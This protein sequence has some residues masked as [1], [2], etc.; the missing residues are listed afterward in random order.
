MLTPVASNQD[1]EDIAFF[2]RPGLTGDARTVSF[3]SVNFPK[4]FLRHQAYRMK[5]H[6]NDDADLFRK[7][8]TFW[9]RTRSPEPA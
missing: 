6:R 1:S 8:A 2:V 9:V 7:D 4:H 3:E 5:L